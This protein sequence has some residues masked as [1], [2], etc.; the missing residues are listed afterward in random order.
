MNGDNNI[1]LSS[2]NICLLNHKLNKGITKIGHESTIYT[3]Y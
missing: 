1:N 2:N 3:R